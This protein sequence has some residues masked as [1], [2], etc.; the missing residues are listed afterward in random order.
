MN[1]SQQDRLANMEDLLARIGEKLQKL[2]EQE[3]PNK[4]QMSKDLGF[5]RPSLDN[6]ISQG[7]NIKLNNLLRI[8]AYLNVTVE[9]FLET[10]PINESEVSHLREK[11]KMQEYIIKKL[12]PNYGENDWSRRPLNYDVFEQ[13]REIMQYNFRASL[14]SL[15]ELGAYKNLREVSDEMQIS[16]QYLHKICNQEGR[17]PGVDHLKW[18]KDNHKIDATGG[19]TELI[20]DMNNTAKSQKSL[21]LVTVK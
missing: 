6:Y 10:A 8:L 1:A 5:T 4:T 14:M 20:Q 18:L 12:D 15:I 11:V 16:Y 7:S 9:E 13:L 17:G 3:K 19:L 21:K 2:F